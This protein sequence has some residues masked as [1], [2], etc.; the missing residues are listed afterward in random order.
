LRRFCAALSVDWHLPHVTPVLGTTHI[1]AAN[2]WTG[3]AWRRHA[4]TLAPALPH[5]RHPLLCCGGGPSGRFS[6]PATKR[7]LGG[8]ELRRGGGL[9]LEAT[10]S[11][12]LCAAGRPAHPNCDLFA[13][14]EWVRWV[15]WVTRVKWVRW[16]KWVK[17]VL[18]GEILR[19]HGTAA[20]VTHENYCGAQIR[21]RG[22]G[23]H[24]P[25]RRRPVLL[26]LRG[27]LDQLLDDGAQRAAQRLPQVAAQGPAQERVRVAA[28]TPSG[29][30]SGLV[31]CPS[32]WNQQHT[33]VT[34]V[35]TR[36]L[37]EVC[38]C[39]GCSCLEI[40]GLETGWWRCCCDV[41]V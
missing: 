31:F 13:A 9:T 30:L 15:E 35:C 6:Q 3:P 11:C 39:G 1:D 25:A 21:A 18:G 26:R 20:D 19:A 5:V 37:T 14:R 10:V 28:S 8:G 16:V 32:S 2:A 24:N 17:W 7:P 34:R 23:T 41:M 40:E 38:L 12:L 29:R 4:G 36:V 33:H 27:H 22:E